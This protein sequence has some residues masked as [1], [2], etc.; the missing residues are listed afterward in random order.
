ME[1]LGASPEHVL[2][3]MQKAIEYVLS[4]QG[5]APRVHVSGW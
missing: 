1:V 5:V 4:S 2:Y 3:N